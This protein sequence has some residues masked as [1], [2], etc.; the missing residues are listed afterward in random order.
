M[1]KRLMVD[2]ETTAIGTDAA[3]WQIGYHEIG[4]EYSGIFNLNPYDQERNV[5][6]DTVEWLRDNAPD[7]NILEPMFNSFFPSKAIL[8]AF[9]EKVRGEE[10]DEIWCKGAD[11]DFAILRSIYAQYYHPLPWHYRKQCCMRSFLNT[12]PEFEIDFSE[13][14]SHN[15]EYDAKVQAE[16]IEKILRHLGRF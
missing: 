3:V 14:Q 9:D 2:I 8:K 13:Q 10:F 15:A 12:F 4:G 11:F 5:N 16:C 6:P 1:K 7:W